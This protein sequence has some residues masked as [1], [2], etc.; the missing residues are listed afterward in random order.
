MEGLHCQIKTQ[1]TKAKLTFDDVAM[2]QYT[3]GTTGVSKG[4][5]LTH[6]N[7]SKQVQQ[8]SSWFPKFHTVPTTSIWAPCLSSM[9]SACPAR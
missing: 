3:G 6:G 9:C 7:I 5:I 2:Y 8:I 4:V 1:S